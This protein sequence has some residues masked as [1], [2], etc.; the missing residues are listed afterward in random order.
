MLAVFKLGLE[1]VAL[2]SNAASG[3]AGRVS[4]S[5]IICDATV[6]LRRL[7]WCV[8]VPGEPDLR[9]FVSFQRRPGASSCR[10]DRRACGSV[11]PPLLLSRAGH[12]ACRARGWAMVAMPQP[13]PG[14][15]FRH[16]SWPVEASRQ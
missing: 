10:N 16:S 9:H 6:R 12:R 4:C 2:G 11:V 15:S 3:A 13:S 8:L 1:G 14:S 5:E 7:K